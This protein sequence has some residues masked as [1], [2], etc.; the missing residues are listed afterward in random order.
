MRIRFLIS[1]L[2]LIVPLLFS[3]TSK[4]NNKTTSSYFVPKDTVVDTSLIAIIPF[5][6]G[7]DLFDK[8]YKPATLS[9]TDLKKIEGFLNKCVKNY[10]D[11]LS[12]DA[13]ISWHISTSYYRQYVAA[14]SANGEK[15]VWLNC[16]C[17]VENEDW[18][19]SLIMVMDGGSCY[20]SLMINLTNKKYYDLIVNGVA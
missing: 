16:M 19:K 1:L 7:Q 8:S 4:T 18:K 12:K 3:C 10:N 6:Q 15:V 20:F 5:E 13:R 11:K 17:N 9:Q 2:I 14:I